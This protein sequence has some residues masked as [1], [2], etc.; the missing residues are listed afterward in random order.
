MP[1]ARQ[2]RPENRFFVYVYMNPFKPLSEKV[3]FEN[4]EFAFQPFYIGYGQ[5]KRDVSHLEEV[6]K[7][8]IYDRR[9]NTIKIN[10]IKKILRN[11]EKP[12]IVRIQDKMLSHDALAL[13]GRLVKF[14]GKIKDKS[15]C[16][17]NI[18]DGGY[19]N[20]VLPG[21][22][23]PMYG[24]PLSKESLQRGVAKRK[25]WWNDPANAEAIKQ[26]NQNKKEAMAR[27]PKE[28]K[29]RI[30][31]KVIATK[32]LANPFGRVVV[33]IKRLQKKLRIESYY[34]RVEENRKL[35]AIYDSRLKFQ[36]YSEEMKNEWYDKH[37]RGENNPMFGQG[38]KLKAEKNGRAKIYK[39]IVNGYTFI[40]NGKLRE[41][42][43]SFMKHFKCNDP[44]RGHSFRKK[45][46]VSVEEIESYDN[47]ENYI[48]FK[49]SSSF[50]GIPL[51]MFSKCKDHLG[52]PSK[53]AE[54]LAAR[55]KRKESLAST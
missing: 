50:D 55:A 17:S 43:L 27:I 53:N 10:I 12:I 11:G 22:L 34:E 54:K 23:N 13:E 39:F 18:S 14:F 24:K 36:D 6:L 2:D 47:L 35:N 37:C 51:N 41:F 20:P 44:L 45:Y 48:L 5:K 15:G 49:D 1:Y 25:I 46:G 28:E 42:R 52:Q 7:D 3:V 16:L 29:T 31:K 19:I 26:I 9:Q 30:Y 4:F 38:H 33:D 8:R 21:K 32:F 40:L